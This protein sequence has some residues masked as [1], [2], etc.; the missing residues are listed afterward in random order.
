MKTS[1][2]WWPLLIA[3]VWLPQHTRGADATPW[4]LD[5]AQ[6]R[7][8]DT[9]LHGRLP[10]W[11]DLT[12]N[13]PVATLAGQTLT[14]TGSDTARPTYSFQI[15]DRRLEVGPGLEGVTIRT[16]PGTP[17]GPAIATPDP[18]SG[19]QITW[20]GFHSPRFGRDQFRGGFAML[21]EFGTM[22]DG[23]LPAGIHLCLP[24]EGKTFLAGRFT[25][26]GL[27][28]AAIKGPLQIPP[29]IN[30]AYLHLG[31][32][33]PA[34]KDPLWTGGVDVEI[35]PSGEVKYTTFLSG[36]P[37]GIGTTVKIN[38]QKQ[39]DYL[40][41]GGQP[42]WHL[43]FIGAA[44]RDTTPPPSSPTPPPG[45]PSMPGLHMPK[46]V[47]QPRLYAVQWVEM[48]DPRTVV[49]RPLVCD[50]AHLGTLRVQAPGARDGTIITFLPLLPDGTT[51]NPD[52]HGISPYLRLRIQN[53]TAP[54]YQL[55]AGSYEFLCLGVRQTVTIETG[56]SHLLKWSF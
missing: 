30:E 24:D 41:R 13:P 26:S 52:A 44:K 55:P 31:S 17:P 48:K 27:Q 4:S 38:H 25:L 19:I 6:L 54:A 3:T 37:P 21:L 32:V 35:A 23:T 49:E 16:A 34:Q 15:T 56:R 18:S 39:G 11:P 5:P 43:I 40:L 50:P 42:G 8:P 36:G 12:A 33:G 20:G 10:G 14:I 51:P 45:F 28:L 7:I 22:K 46:I 1:S 47:P 29:A 53:G 9:P 2:P